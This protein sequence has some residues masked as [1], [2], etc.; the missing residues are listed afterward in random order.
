MS[1]YV[2]N[3]YWQNTSEKHLVLSYTVNIFCVTDL[4]QKIPP[5]SKPDKF[6][7]TF[8]RVIFWPPF[9]GFWYDFEIQTVQPL[10]KC[11]II[12]NFFGHFQILALLTLT[13]LFNVLHEKYALRNKSR[14]QEYKH[15]HYEITQFIEQTP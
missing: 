13:K 10:R 12:Y 14:Q 1:S 2:V 6:E 11:F 7:K 9:S 4:F 15:R 3:G 5:I 8:M